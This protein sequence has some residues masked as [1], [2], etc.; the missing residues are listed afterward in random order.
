M[1]PP[2]HKIRSETIIV[3]FSTEKEASA[4]VRSAPDFASRLIQPLLLKIF[5]EHTQN[6]RTLYIEKL[7]VDLGVISPG[8]F[9][10]SLQREIR[11]QLEKADTAARPV[12]ETERTEN[13]G[14]GPGSSGRSARSGPAKTIGALCYFLDRGT[15]PW[16]TP[17]QTLKELRREIARYTAKAEQAGGMQEL[18]TLLQR[19]APARKRLFFQ[20]S[21]AFATR[22]L[23]EALPSEMARLSGVREAIA[24][25]SLPS[26]SR[27]RLPD[28]PKTGP[29]AARIQKELAGWIALH[30]PEHT[31]TW[32]GSYTAF[33]FSAIL[34]RL[35]SAERKTLRQT[36]RSTSGTRQ[37]EAQREIYRYLGAVGPGAG[38]E[39]TPEN[40][41]KGIFGENTGAA[42][43]GKAAAGPGAARPERKAAGRSSQ[44]PANAGDRGESMLSPTVTSAPGKAHPGEGKPG[45][46][47]AVRESA[48]RGTQPD[49]S[50]PGYTDIRNTG[51]SATGNAGAGTF[52]SSEPYI[53]APDTYPPGS[54]TGHSPGV[55]Y[56]GFAGIILTWPYLST[57]FGK[58]KYLEN[59]QFR[60]HTAQQR[61]IQLLGW[62]ASGK[63]GNEEPDLILPKIICGYPADAPVNGKIRLTRTEKEN[64]SEML[65]SLIANWPVLGNT[66]IDGLRSSFF[67]REGK[68]GR[69]AGKWRLVVGQK[70]FDMLLERLSYGISIVKLP[71][72]D[73]LIH[74]DW[75]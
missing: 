57:L 66:S 62:I 65:R 49:T 63:S 1:K 10:P 33:L 47:Q 59:K 22:L 18:Y 13:A 67:H 56:S 28:Y 60:N 58:L 5:D 2:V 54:P 21:P 8:E 6:G 11:K 35:T 50:R 38:K 40:L 51:K 26:L 20:F 64:A 17:F 32:I 42:G 12:T 16:N 70:S 71:W 69:E 30:A 3:N 61:A 43:M 52:S 75:A 72:N 31:S 53:P 44:A 37:N 7:E 45:E 41:M 73:Y 4:W 55:Y 25:L 68:L 39:Q 29:G 23:V 24:G 34:P 15:F 46:W 9:L 36:A 48:S 19:S 74:T 14:P 27:V